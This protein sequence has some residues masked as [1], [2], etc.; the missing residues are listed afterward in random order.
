M[1]IRFAYR[2]PTCRVQEDRFVRKEAA[3]EQYCAYDTKTR[4]T[5]LPAGPSTT[6]RFAD[7]KLK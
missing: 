3:D 5:R 4:M 7:R 1:Y 2:C 6:F